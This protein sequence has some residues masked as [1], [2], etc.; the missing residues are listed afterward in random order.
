MMHH[1]TTISSTRGSGPWVLILAPAASAKRAHAPR[2]VFYGVL[3]SAPAPA[4]DLDEWKTDRDTA[5]AV[6][7]SLGIFLICFVWGL[8]WLR[9]CYAQRSREAYLQGEKDG[10]R[11]GGVDVEN[12]RDWQRSHN[13]RA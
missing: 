2:R 8:C 10:L 11:G 7:L 4:R 12:P 5:F 13:G 1:C 9:E 3:Y 6:G